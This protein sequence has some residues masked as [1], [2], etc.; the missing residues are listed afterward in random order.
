M[1]FSPADEKTQRIRNAENLSDVRPGVD[2]F[3]IA[4]GSFR[5]HCRV[6]AVIDFDGQAV[7]LR[8]TG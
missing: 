1:R 2:H 5:V 4:T 8:Y 7:Q 6:G 3:Q